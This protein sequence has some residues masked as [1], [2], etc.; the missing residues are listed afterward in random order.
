MVTPACTITEAD[1]AAVEESIYRWLLFELDGNTSLIVLAKR[2]ALEDSDQLTSGT[3]PWVSRDLN[4]LSEDVFADYLSVNRNP[5]DLP[6]NLHLITPYYFIDDLMDTYTPENWDQAWRLFRTHFRSASGYY[7]I[8][9]VGLNCT[10]DRALIY[11][12]KSTPGS[13]DLLSGWR[14]FLYL[15]S[16]SDGQWQ[17]DQRTLVSIS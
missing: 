1:R 2:R 16:L 10:L 9:R 13:A 12:G 6:S 15:L 4:L 11:V 17:I 14:A 3:W 5:S 7:V 8:S